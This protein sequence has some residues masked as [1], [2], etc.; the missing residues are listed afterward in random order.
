MNIFSSKS[1]TS[2]KPVSHIEKPKTDKPCKHPPYRITFWYAYNYETGENDIP[3]AGCCDC[4]EII[5]GGVE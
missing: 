5:L 2:S 4:G 3:C 1:A